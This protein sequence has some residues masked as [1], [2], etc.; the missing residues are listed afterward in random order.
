MD[1]D[2]VA[3][4]LADRREERLFIVSL[5]RDGIAI[6]IITYGEIYDGIHGGRDPASAERELQTFP[7]TAPVLPLNRPI[8]RRFA[9]LRGAMRQRHDVVGDPDLLI[10]ATAIQ[11]GRTLVTRNLRDFQRIPGLAIHS[12][13]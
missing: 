5:R 8:M 7:T 3:D 2:W 11:S 10:A 6:S 4:Y 12:L 1:T 9:P 13:P